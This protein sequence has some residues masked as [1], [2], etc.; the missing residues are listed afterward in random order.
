MNCSNATQWLGVL[1]VP[2]MC[3][4]PDEAPEHRAPWPVQPLR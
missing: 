2:F 3:G 1:P 4:E